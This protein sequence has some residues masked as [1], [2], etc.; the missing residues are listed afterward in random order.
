MNARIETLDIPLWGH[1]Q[2][3][4]LR[5]YRPKFENK[6]L[7]ILLFFQGGGFTHGNLDR[8]D[9]AASEL[10]GFLPA[11]VISV[12]YS[13][14]PAFPF[15]TAP[16][17]AYLALAWAASNARLFKA[18]AKRIA[19]AGHDA[20]GNIAN[21]LSTMARDRGDFKVV[22]QALMAPLLDPSMTQITLERDDEGEET[23]SECFRCYRAY[24]PT[25]MQ[26]THPYAAPIESH[27]LAGMPPTLIASAEHD[28]VQKDGERYAVALIAAGVPT[29]VARHKKLTHQGVLDDPI[30]LSDVA[31]FLHKYLYA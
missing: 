21:C 7:P 27:C 16:E 31:T 25:L 20:G 10:S 9:G 6:I 12:G 22:A 29:Q 1:V 14:A 19:V 2:R 8:A 13:L 18:D 30:V 26:R 24:L 11:W 28:V 23:L 15:P 3:I 5:T 4:T 17:D